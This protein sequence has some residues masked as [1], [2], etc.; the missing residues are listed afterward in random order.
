M[1]LFRFKNIIIKQNL[2]RIAL[3]M[4]SEKNI[5][6]KYMHVA[7]AMNTL[8]FDGA[9]I[10]RERENNCF[11]SFVLFLLSLYS[12]MIKSFNATSLLL[13]VFTINDPIENLLCILYHIACTQ[14]Y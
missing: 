6:C 2:E 3:E 8:S 1:F 7:R 5:Q 10:A 11:D 12:S 14:K 13:Y 9:K 4:N